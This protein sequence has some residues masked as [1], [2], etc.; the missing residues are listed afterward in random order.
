M[1]HIEEVRNY[2]KVRGGFAVRVYEIRRGRE[3]LFGDEQGYAPQRFRV[4][5]PIRRQVAV[6]HRTPVRALELEDA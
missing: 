6:P 5:E 2:F 3:Y 1:S 4:L